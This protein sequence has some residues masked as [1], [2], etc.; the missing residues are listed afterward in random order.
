M[1]FTTYFPGVGLLPGSVRNLI[2]LSLSQPA[3][4]DLVVFATEQ[5]N[6]NEHCLNI[7]KLALLSARLCNT[8]TL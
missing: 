8:N 3:H 5:A 1:Y 2:T 6:F 4:S 7:Q